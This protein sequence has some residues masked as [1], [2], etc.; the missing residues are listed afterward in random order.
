MNCSQPTMDSETIIP[1][2]ILKAK[3][4]WILTVLLAALLINLGC[5]RNDTARIAIEGVIE[6]DT[7]PL[8]PVVVSFVPRS[9]GARGCAFTSTDGSF[10]VPAE[11][12]PTPGS[13]D[14]IVTSWEPDLETFEARK[15]AGDP[16]FNAVSIP[17]KYLKPGGLV[18]ELPVEFN[19][20]L[21]L[22]L[23]TP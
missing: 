14:V 19:E 3:N 6:L 15:S 20:P 17:S 16:P 10:A 11:F 8:G 7:K 18:V 12:G 4:P 2:S 23:N 9:S 22:Q 5:G 1:E 21:M 13:Y